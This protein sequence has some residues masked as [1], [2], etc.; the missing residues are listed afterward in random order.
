LF[1]YHLQTIKNVREAAAKTYPRPIALAL[2]T[3]GPE[4]RTG[5]MKSVCIFISILKC[6]L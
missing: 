4:I 2:D 1:Q 5:M 6:I 3:K